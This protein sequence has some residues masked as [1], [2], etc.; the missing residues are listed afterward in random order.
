M[1]HEIRT[2]MNAIIGLTHLLR[3]DGDPAQ[4]GQLDKIDGAGRHLLSIINDILDLSKIEAGRLHWKAPTFPLIAVLDTSLDDR[5]NGAAKGLRSRST[6]T[7]SRSGCA[8]T[9]RGCARPAQLR[10]QRRQVH[11]AGRHR[12]ARRLLETTAS[13]AGALRGE[14][15]GIGIAADNTGRL[16]QAFE[17]ADPRPRASTAAP[18]WGWPSPAAWRN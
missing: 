2:P 3:R 14:D 1:S 13:P 9:R 11:R 16:F 12:P 5:P 18:A 15:T 8:A 17:Q 4:A 10:R 6:P 7:P